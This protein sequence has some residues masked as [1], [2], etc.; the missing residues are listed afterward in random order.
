MKKLILLLL[1]LF[2]IS[3]TKGE[4]GGGLGA[5]VLF[6]IFLAALQLIIYGFGSKTI[7]S[8]AKLN[9]DFSIILGF[10]LGPVWLVISLIRA[11]YFSLK[12]V[13]I[14]VVRF[15]VIS[16]LVTVLL[17]FF[18]GVPDIK[19]LG[20][21]AFFPL[22]VWFFVIPFSLLGEKL[23][24]IKLDKVFSNDQI[25]NNPKIKTERNG[26]KST[27]ERNEAIGYLKR[28]NQEF[29]NNQFVNAIKYYTKAIEIDSNFKEAYNNRDKAR[30]KL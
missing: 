12:N 10:I 5:F 3:C 14:I 8:S 19:Y 2:I 27:S 22:I 9:T 6:L 25:N 23:F 26:V 15:I 28:G 16:I 20:I 18:G 29:K 21:W 30:K 17:E 4:G 11:N 7:L 13:F 1:P 24:H